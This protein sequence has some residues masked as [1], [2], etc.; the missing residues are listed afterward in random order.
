MTRWLLISGLLLYS[1]IITA[2]DVMICYN[3]SC[4]ATARIELSDEQLEVVHQLFSDVAD[5]ESERAKISDAIG[6]FEVY[7]GQQSPTGADRGG[8]WDDQNI[9]GRMDCIDHST[10]TTT[11]LKLIDRKSVV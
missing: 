6:V 8:N 9:N 10:N 5:A 4:A 7:A 2:D 3:W 1:S 11:Y